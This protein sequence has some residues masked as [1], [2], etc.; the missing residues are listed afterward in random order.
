MKNG[1][2]LHALALWIPD[3]RSI[4][5][6]QKALNGTLDSAYLEYQEQV[7]DSAVGSARKIFSLA[8]IAVGR[9][10]LQ[11]ALDNEKRSPSAWKPSRTMASELQRLFWAAWFLAAA[12][13]AGDDAANRKLL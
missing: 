11:Q 8:V 12:C 1:D 13:V 4:D 5:A 6:I 2:V 9:G 10:A 3:R 7:P